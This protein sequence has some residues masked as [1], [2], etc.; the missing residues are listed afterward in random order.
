[1]KAL[2]KESKGR[3]QVHWLIFAV[4]TELTIPN[5]HAFLCVL[6]SPLGMSWSLSKDVESARAIRQYLAMPVTTVADHRCSSLAKAKPI[7]PSRCMQPAL[8]GRAARCMYTVDRNFLWMQQSLP[9][10]RRDRVVA[11]Y[12]GRHPAHVNRRQ[13]TPL[14][15]AR[16]RWPRH[17]LHN[18]HRSASNSQMRECKATQDYSIV[19][20]A[21]VQIC[22]APE[23][24]L[25]LVNSVLKRAFFLTHFRRRILHFLMDWKVLCKCSFV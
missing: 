25:V 22:S 9:L 8:H 2:W 20:N 24:E 1:L 21:P 6:L 11:I 17:H 10:I 4:M 18:L 23:R 15:L 12:W 14:L 16:R 3:E 7:E 5:G 13:V 19:L